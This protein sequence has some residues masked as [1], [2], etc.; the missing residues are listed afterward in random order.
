MQATRKAINAYAHASE[1]VAPAQQIVLLYEGAIRRIREARAAI[2]AQ[3]I[4]ERC[5][6]VQKATAIVEGLQSCLDHA[7]GGQIA[8]DLDRI[9]SHVVFRLHRINLTNDPAICDEVVA[10]LD[11]LRAAWAQLAAG[12]APLTGGRHVEAGARNATATTI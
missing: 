8:R 5:M 11:P 10:L 6:A 9:Y 2:Q 12:A 7:R 4:S 3:R 1:T